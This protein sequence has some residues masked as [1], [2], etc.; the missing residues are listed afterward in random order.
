MSGINLSE[1]RDK[2]KQAEAL[3]AGV[4]DAYARDGRIGGAR[5]L[6]ECTLALLDEIAELEKEMAE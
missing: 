5:L 2:L 3:I 4:R 1:M 6:N